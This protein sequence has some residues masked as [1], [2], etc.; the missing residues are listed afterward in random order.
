MTLAG[1]EM[2]FVQLPFHYSNMSW[3]DAEA[4]CKKKGTSLP[5][6]TYRE[7]LQLFVNDFSTSYKVYVLLNSVSMMLHYAIYSCCQLI[8][9]CIF[10]C[11]LA[12]TLYLKSLKIFIF[13]EPSS[14]TLVYK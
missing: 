13:T 4:Y 9:F 1:I 5:S 12:I 2:N 6:V 8:T 11:F 10:V 7:D 14:V 3:L